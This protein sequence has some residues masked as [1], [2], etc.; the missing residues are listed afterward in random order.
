MRTP[1]VWLL[2]VGRAGLYIALVWFFVWA[3]RWTR[4]KSPILGAILAVGIIVRAALGSL[5]FAISY[6]ELPFLAGLQL[7]GGFW[8]LALDARTYFFA[9]ASAVDSGISTIRDGSAS[10]V[11]VRLLALWMD[12]VGVSPASAALLNL[13]TYVLIAMLIVAA[14]RAVVSAAI[15]LGAVTLSPALI[16]FGTQALKD[17]L[18]VMLI[19]LALAGARLWVESLNGTSRHPQKDGVL[20]ATYLSAAVYGLGGLRPYIAFFV[21]V[22]VFAMALA[23]IVMA[24]G[25]KERWKPFAAYAVLVP[26]LWLMFMTGAGAYYPYYASFVN[27]ALG[28]P[29]RL[30]AALDGART[31]FVES[32]GATSV[33]A[34]SASDDVP[35]FFLEFVGVT[36]QGLVAR[37]VRALRGWAIMFLPITLLRAL[38]LVSFTGGRGLLVVTDLDTLVM[39]AGI[40]A[41]LLLLLRKHQ[42]HGS[43]PVTVFALVLAAVTVVS[44]AYVVTNY[45]TLFRLRLLAVTQ[46][47][48][49]PAF[50]GRAS[51]EHLSRPE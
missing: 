16:I 49:L 36:G 35:P 51:G 37:A 11:Y 7:G 15:A 1:A 45:G 26:L 50:V 43:R 48:V 40:I 32:G 44:M 14:S 19:V 22:S 10:P 8:T 20:G 28:H 13:L 24:S 21:V 34:G 30:V 33:V 27:A 18:C 38:S 2:L 25:R 4:T 29:W 9:A 3:F 23:A 47:W 39:D 42:Q 41:S 12:L 17:S 5:L 31:G 46:I 6:F